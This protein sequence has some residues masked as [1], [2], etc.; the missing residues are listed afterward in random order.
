M[1]MIKNLPRQYQD[2]PL[3]KYLDAAASHMEFDPSDLSDQ[4]ILETMTWQLPVEEK[5]AGLSTVVDDV[6]SRKDFL[7][8]KWLSQFEHVGIPGLQK[9]ADS[10]RNG[11]IDVEFDYPV[12]SIAFTSEYGVPDYIDGF[13]GAIQKIVPAHLRVDYL[14]RYETHGELKEYTHE[15]L[16]SN[17]HRD[18]REGTIET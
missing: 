16:S 10:F 11:G 3:V 9:I 17:I 12:I 4:M 7:R 13:K 14:F 5:I 1:S 6:E 18:I 15:D 8:A 2:S